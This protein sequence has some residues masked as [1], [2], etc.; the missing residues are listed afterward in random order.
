MGPEMAFRCANAPLSNVHSPIGADLARSAFKTTLRGAGSRRYRGEAVD[1]R[2]G[3]RSP[4]EPL[5]LDDAL[6]AGLKAAIPFKHSVAPLWEGQPRAVRR[7]VGVSV[8]ADRVTAPERPLGPRIGC[9]RLGSRVFVRVGPD[10]K[11]DP[12]LDGAR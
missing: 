6:E 10:A 9:G 3:T 4:V 7:L 8:N 2:P 5:Q 12:G 1:R 11:G